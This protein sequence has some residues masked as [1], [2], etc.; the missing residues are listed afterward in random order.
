MNILAITIIIVL[1][2]ISY[3]ATNDIIHPAVVTSGIWGII[4]LI[5]NIIN[6][7]LY[8]LSDKFYFALLIWVITFCIISIWLS[9]LHTPFPS[10]L[11]GSFNKQ[12]IKY[13]TPILVVCLL[14]SIFALIKKGLYYNSDN[15][16]SGIR[17]ASVSQ[18]NGEQPLIEFP[19]YIK[20]A[21]TISGFSFLLLLL[22]MFVDDNKNNRVKIILLLLL[23][24][25]YYVLRSN[26]TVMAQL[27]LSFFCM[28]YIF[29][30]ID[31]KKIVIFIFVFFVLMMLSQLLRRDIGG[32]DFLQFITAYLL[33]P[34]PA[35][36]NVLADNTQLIHSFNGEYTFR[37][38]VPLF[39]YFDPTIVGNPDPFNLYNWTET[40][41]NVNV[42]TIMFSY[43]VDFGF[44]GLFLFS[45]LLGAFWGLLY[46]FMRAGYDVCKLIY[47]AFFYMLIFQF[48]SDS[49]FQFFL[50]TLSIILFS[51]S[52][53]IKIKIK[54]I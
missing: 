1:C 44:F 20:I 9:K 33:A 10:F 54:Q 30:K 3:K 31:F 32:F 39:Q 48:F 24:L 7:G 41:V 17:A 43:Y 35:F 40:P 4:V 27:L 6:H 28:L 16:F 13:L 51:C 46:Q 34:L 19:F 14:F 2:I 52:L 53:F 37:F 18:L 50:V 49:F 42:Y 22:I 38:L 45:G 36:D 21:N 29:K 25:F 8:P 23:V 11:K 47:A 12:V 26:K 15:L 5:Y